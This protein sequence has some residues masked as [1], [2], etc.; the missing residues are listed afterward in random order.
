MPVG[1]REEGEP[2][3]RVK[4]RR[5]VH[6][7]MTPNV[8]CLRP[9]MTVREAEKLLAERSVSGAPVVDDRGR[10]LGVVSQSDLVSHRS[11]RKTV[12]EV[13]RFYTDVED[14]REIEKIAANCSSTPIE[15]IMS[16][17]VYRV[18]RDTGVATAA[19]VMRERRV[20]RLLVTDRGVV[21]GVV[22]ALDLLR[23]VEELP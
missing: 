6:E 2:K 11:T 10:P 9:E 15:K 14:Y 17:R 7:F 22:S 4:A 3:S 5:R 21:V 8:L 23:I 18:A 13:G 19:S 1:K 20:H 16:Q 12:K